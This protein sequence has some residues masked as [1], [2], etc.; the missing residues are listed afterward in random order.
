MREQAAKSLSTISAELS[1]SEMQSVFAPAVVRL[2]QADWFVG[3][4]SSCHLFACAYPR[5]NAN[6]ER[7]RKKFIELCQE[8]TPMIRRACASK[9]GE[10]A[11]CLEKQHV[12]QDLMPVFRQLS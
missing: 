12:I 1:D 6:K 8:D 9:L 4:V 2:A 11:T 5:S 10:F 3:R 7:L